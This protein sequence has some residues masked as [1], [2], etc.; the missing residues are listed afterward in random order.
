MAPDDARPVNAVEIP[1]DQALVAN[2]VA[3]PPTVTDDSPAARVNDG[4]IVSA[5]DPTPVTSV[6]LPAL[7]AS[8]A[9]P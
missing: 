8:E 9:P 1:A 2:F 7:I 5:V 4:A 6:A 3:L